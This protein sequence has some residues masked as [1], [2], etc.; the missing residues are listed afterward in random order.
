MSKNQAVP[1]ESCQET[2]QM[3]MM[4][5]GVE[6]L[7]MFRHNETKAISVY[8]SVSCEEAHTWPQP[9]ELTGEAEEK[10]RL[11]PLE[12]GTVMLPEGH[13]HIV[14]LDDEQLYDEIVDVIV[15]EKAIIIGGE[16]TVDA[17]VE[18][19]EAGTDVVGQEAVDLVAR[20]AD[21]PH[22]LLPESVEKIKQASGL[23]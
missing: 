16:E 20:V 3:G 12:R 9:L 1:L 8:R 14:L 10:R 19:P 6:A 23:A 11:M 21:T 18:N 13:M 17:T 15:N 2:H 7:V 5:N 22:G 4:S